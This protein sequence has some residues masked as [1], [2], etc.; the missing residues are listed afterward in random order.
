MSEIN[1]EM[2]GRLEIVNAR[3]VS[4][5]ILYMFLLALP[6]L[7]G[8][9]YYFFKL[10]TIMEIATSTLIIILFFIFGFPAI[11]VL[12]YWL[13]HGKRE[14]KIVI[15]NTSIE[16][17]WLNHLFLQ[18]DWSEI[19]TI[20]IFKERW[21]TM[22][23]RGRIGSGV[24]SGYT[25]QFIGLNIDK[26]VRLWCFPFKYKNQRLIMS[27]L[28]EFSMKLNKLIEIDESYREPIGI[29]DPKCP[30]FAEFYEKYRKKPKS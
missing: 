23:Y 9:I 18:M 19:K 1:G 26:T 13:I 15:T 30:E 16:I 2:E 17:Y 10:P 4:K 14:S 3:K 6:G 12:I 8:L 25:V 24:H 21:K 11:S 7:F 28:Q 5:Y 29:D 22:Y 27:G 20:K